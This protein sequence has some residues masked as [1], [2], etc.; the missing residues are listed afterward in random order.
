[1]KNMIEYNTTERIASLLTLPF[2]SVAGN[3]LGFC[4][5]PKLLGWN[6]LVSVIMSMSSWGSDMSVDTGGCQ[7]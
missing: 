2:E 4:P 7:N 1:M 6:G 3:F 5:E